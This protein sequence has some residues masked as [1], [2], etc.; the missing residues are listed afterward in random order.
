MRRNSE[1]VSLL[2]K[3]K[4][5]STF[6]RCS[7]NTLL[8]LF[9][10]HL[11]RVGLC[12]YYKGVVEENIHDVVEDDQRPVDRFLAV[13]RSYDP[14][15]VVHASFAAVVQDNRQFLIFV[16][17]QPLCEVCSEATC[18]CAGFLGFLPESLSHR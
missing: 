9:K 4:V 12:L 10:W 11:A 1:S 16:I 6:P 2:S 18:P 8:L 3:S 5:M 15:Q 7:R 14:I 17:T 13:V